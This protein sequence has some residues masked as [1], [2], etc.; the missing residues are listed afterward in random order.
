M[1]SF[2]QMFSNRLQ[3]AMLPKRVQQGHHGISLFTPPFAL[4]DVVDLTTITLPQ[5]PTAAHSTSGRKGGR[6]FQLAAD[7]GHPNTDCLVIMP[8]ALIPS[9]DVA[10]ALGVQLRESLLT[11][12]DAFA[13][14][15]R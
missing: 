13:P 9:T 3:C 11:V 14:G 4:G 2:L 1:L 15:S 5:V 8:K 10:V 7:G 12:G 6:C